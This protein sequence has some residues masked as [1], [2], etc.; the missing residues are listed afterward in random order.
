MLPALVDGISKKITGVRPGRRTT[1][2]VRP[3]TFCACTQSAAW[4]T[5]VSM[6]PCAAQSGSNTG[7]LAGMAM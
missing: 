4:R 3:G 2:S 5:T 1:S 6:K 7:D